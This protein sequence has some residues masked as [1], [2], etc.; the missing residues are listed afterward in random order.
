[1]NQA[2]LPCGGRGELVQQSLLDCALRLNVRLVAIQQFLEF[3]EFIRGDDKV[4]SGKPVG[5]SV[6]GSAG[7]A[8]GRAR[9]GAV[10]GI[11]SVGC[12]T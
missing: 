7:L 9:S 6:L 8:F 2:R 11:G 3:L 1:M 5:A 10:Q 4:A 12:Q